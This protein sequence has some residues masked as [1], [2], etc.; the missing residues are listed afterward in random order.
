MN[1]DMSMYVNGPITIL[2]SLERSFEP[3]TYEISRAL[4]HFRKNKKFP[5]PHLMSTKF[6]YYEGDVGEVMT[7]E[8]PDMQTDEFT[9][10]I[11]CDRDGNKLQEYLFRTMSNRMQVVNG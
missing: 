4:E 8:G 11:L 5:I 3:P 6:L 1:V 9:Q 7:D 10:V 2:E